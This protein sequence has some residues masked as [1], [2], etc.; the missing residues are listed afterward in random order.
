MQFSLPLPQ[1]ISMQMETIHKT[2]NNL[3]P[4]L[5]RQS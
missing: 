2:A 1:K 5:F 3:N 4:W